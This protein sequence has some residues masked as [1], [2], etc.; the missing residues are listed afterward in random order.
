MPGV[1]EKYWLSLFWDF[2]HFPR[3]LMICLS[4]VVPFVTNCIFLLFFV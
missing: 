4:Y 2:Y 3:E 1:L